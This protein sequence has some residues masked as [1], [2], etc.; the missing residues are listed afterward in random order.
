MTHAKPDPLPDVAPFL[1]DRVGDVSRPLRGL[2]T[3]VDLAHLP[4]EAGT[5]ATVRNTLGWMRRGNA[6]LLEQHRRFGPIYRTGFAGYTI[7]CVGDPELVHE[8]ARDDRTWSAAL[9][10]VTFF[11]GIDPKLNAAR[12]DSP[13]FLDFAPHRDARKLLQPA[14]NPAAIASYFDAATAIFEP[15]VERW[16]ARGR[17]EFKDAIRSLLVEVS[18]RIF[19][20]VDD[21]AAQL[22][23]ALVD[24]WE[25]PLA[26]VRNRLSAKWRRS[27]RGHRT[28]CEMLRARIAQRR[29][30]GGDDMFSRLCARG[31]GTD[32]VDD[33]GLVR[34]VIGVMAAAFATTSSGLASMA[35]LL[36]THP[37]WQDRMR[38]EAFAVGRGRVSFE[39]S[40]RLEVSTRVWKETMRLFPIAPYYARRALR[41]TQLGPW[42][43]PA[44]TFVLALIAAVMHDP[45]LWDEPLRFDP[46]RFSEARAED[47]KHLGFFLPFG[48]G[49]HTC[50][51]MHLANAEARAFWHIML[52]RCRFSLEREYRAHHTY[53]P[54]GIV[55]GDVKLRIERL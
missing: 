45:A 34:L 44:G 46:D 23:R 38:E 50:T 16:I 48:T 1:L 19:L 37:A 11:G 14:F 40:K 8:I 3:H 31:E 42:K 27:I 39:D 18:T 12:L 7:V 10:W 6:H 22:E 15:A 17:V 35:Y 54:A 49:A 5:L 36:A 51:G 52:T 47:K 53:L 21:A 9:A 13:L 4:G 24:Y 25:G 43:V 41:D 55:S 26:L 2:P 20:G 33:D 32:L 28:L 30:T 29:E